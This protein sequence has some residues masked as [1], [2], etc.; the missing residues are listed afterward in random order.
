MEMMC[1]KFVVILLTAGFWGA[2]FVWQ[3][4]DHSEICRAGSSLGISQAN[5][6]GVQG[7]SNQCECSELLL[8]VGCNSLPLKIKTWWSQETIHWVT[9]GAFCVRYMT[10]NPVVFSPSPCLT[11]MTKCRRKLG[12]SKQKTGKQES[13]PITTPFTLHL[14]RNIRNCLSQMDH[15]FP[16][17]KPPL[18]S[19]RSRLHGAFPNVGSGLKV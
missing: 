14:H 2:L 13:W 16:E 18:P 1:S 12:K 6:P 10:Q 9:L 3:T 19:W 17:G 7:C 4:F 5:Q 11:A 15:I 8:S